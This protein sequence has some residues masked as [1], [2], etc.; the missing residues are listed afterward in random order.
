M[1]YLPEVL[2]N[3]TKLAVN[4]LVTRELQKRKVRK[5]AM[6]GIV[7]SIIGIFLVVAALQ[8]DAH[9][10]KGLD[11]ALK[12]LAHEPFGSLLLSIVALGLIAYGVFSFV[13][14]CYRRVGGG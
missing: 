5:L 12:T 11:S 3:I 1:T 13:E 6:L 10:A 9:Q 14:A 4:V 2:S 8:H 7:F